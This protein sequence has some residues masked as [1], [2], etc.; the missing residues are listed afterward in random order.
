M[1]VIAYG[2]TVVVRKQA[3]GVLSFGGDVIVEVDRKPVRS[4]D[5][6]KKAI[7]GARKG[8]G[9]LFL[10][11]RGESTIFLALKPQR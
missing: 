2:K 3:K 5:D 11:R 6:Y 7:A 8:R 10:V 9:V 4:V 1:E